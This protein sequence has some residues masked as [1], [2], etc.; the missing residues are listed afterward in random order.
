MSSRG[1]RRHRSC[2][3]HSARPPPPPRGEAV[4]LHR[5][6]AQF[7]IPVA[8]NFSQQTWTLMPMTRFGLSVGFPCRRRRCCQRRLSARPASIAAS[9]EPRRRAAGGRGGLRRVPQPA[10]DVDA[11]RLDL[12]GLRILV[13]VDHVLVEALGHEPLGLRLHP[14]RDKRREVQAGVAVEHQLVVDDLV[15]DV[16]RHLTVGQLV[17]RNALALECEDRRNREVI[18]PRRRSARVHSAEVVLLRL[19]RRCRRCHGSLLPSSS[20]ARCSA[21]ARASASYVGGESKRDAVEVIALPGRPRTSN[22]NEPSRYPRGG[23]A[24]P[25]A[26]TLLHVSRALIRRPFL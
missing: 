9:L 2:S 23:G 6:E 22:R 19:R 17:T 21:F 13:L 11:A 8:A 7:D 1:S 24:A 5:H 26:L 12:R 10:E 3:R 14:R 16:R 20:L 18:S 4:A 15:G 25:R